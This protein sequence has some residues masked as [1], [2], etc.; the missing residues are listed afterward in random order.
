MSQESKKIFIPVDFCVIDKK[1]Y[2][3]GYTFASQ[4]NLPSPVA[5]Y[6]ASAFEVTPDI[7]FEGFSTIPAFSVLGYTTK[8]VCPQ[9]F[10]NCISL[11]RLSIPGVKALGEGIYQILASKRGNVY[12]TSQGVWLLSCAEARFLSDAEFQA[13]KDSLQFGNYN[14]KTGTDTDDSTFNYPFEVVI[15]DIHTSLDLA[16]LTPAPDKNLVIANIKEQIGDSI[17]VPDNVHIVSTDDCCVPALSCPKHMLACDANITKAIYA[18]ETCNFFAVSARNAIDVSIPRIVTGILPYIWG[19]FSLAVPEN[20]LTLDMSLYKS[21]KKCV[22]DA[23]T[24]SDDSFLCLGE[25]N[26]ISLKTYPKIIRAHARGLSESISLAFVSNRCL[27][28]ESVDVY[29]EDINVEEMT[30]S[31]LLFSRVCYRIHLTH[32]V[33]IK[34]LMIDNLE[35]NNVVIKSDNAIPEM[36]IQTGG[37]IRVEAPNIG[38]LELENSVDDVYSLSN[39]TRCSV[40]IPP[41]SGLDKVKPIV[42]VESAVDVTTLVPQPDYITLKNWR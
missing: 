24:L 3:K 38:L 27:V 32:T 5:Y 4:P 25:T 26:Y 15:R 29:L 9:P 18:P 19:N 23:E 41:K 40:S 8:Y 35:F 33:H 14:P 22:I 10:N 12:D 11:P 28:P 17:V 7:V 39:V 42:S 34:R 37:E 1:Y 2:L 30:F 6:I 36:Q 16:C 31:P 13:V 20:S 21:L